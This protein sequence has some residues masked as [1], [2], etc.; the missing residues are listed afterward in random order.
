MLKTNYVTIRGTKEGLILYL[1]DECSFSELVSELEEKLS[2][3]YP[4]ISE[5]PAVHVK[6]SVGN[7]YLSEPQKEQLISIISDQQKLVINQ[8]ESNIIT[9]QEAENLQKEAQT[10]T[11]IRVIRSGQVLE[12]KGNL[13]LLG[14]VN[15]GGTVVATGNIY[16]LGVLRGIAHAGSEG[17]SE[18]VIAASKMEPSQ[19]RIAEIVSRSPDTKDNESHDMEC[20]YVGYD[21]KIAIER[22]QQMG[23]IRPGITNVTSFEL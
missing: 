2:S 11:I 9:K 4:Q 15:P 3:N 13:L 10:A 5:G 16:I 23:K 6:V 21:N 1:D 14:D 22:I 12:V 7:R 20:A 17:D 18:A 19:L 8:I